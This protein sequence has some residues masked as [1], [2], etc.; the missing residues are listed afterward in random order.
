M[1]YSLRYNYAESDTFSQ[2]NL[3]HYFRGKLDNSFPWL[4]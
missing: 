1:F 3:T 4:F 2:V